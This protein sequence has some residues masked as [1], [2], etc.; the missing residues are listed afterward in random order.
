[1]NKYGNV[2]TIVDGKKFD[3][4]REANRYCELKLMQRAGLITDLMWQFPF[5]LIPGQR[6]N[7]KQVERPVRYTADFVYYENGKLVVEDVKSEATKTKEYIIKRKLML[8]LYGI[9]IRE[10]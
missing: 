1:M 9:R 4:K 5:K 3:S 6:I 8:W 10:V 7:G 2:E